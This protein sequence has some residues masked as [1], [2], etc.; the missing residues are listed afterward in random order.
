MPLGVLEDASWEQGSV[1]IASGDAVLFYTDGIP[2]AQNRQEEF[3]GDK[4]LLEVAQSNLGRSAQ[5]MQDALLGEAHRFMGDAPQLDD[6][7]LMVVVRE[8]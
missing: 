7:T 8:S 5:N 1:Q 2:E 4:R 3:F 6:I